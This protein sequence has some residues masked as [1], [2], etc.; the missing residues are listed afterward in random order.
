M[1]I[2]LGGEDRRE[3][4]RGEEKRR[5]MDGRCMVER[6]A[7]R[8]VREAKTH[9]PLYYTQKIPSRLAGGT[10][11]AASMLGRELGGEDQSASARGRT[12]RSSEQRSIG[13]HGTQLNNS[14]IRM[15]SKNEIP[16]SRSGGR[17]SFVSGSF[18]V[19]VRKKHRPQ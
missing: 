13:A 17:P 4:K 12:E 16:R 2:N 18:G 8:I 6:G 10:T 15:E 1:D 19:V 11:I 14:I 7:P 5:Y 3:E 9:H